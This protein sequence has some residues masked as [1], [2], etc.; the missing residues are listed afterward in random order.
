QLVRTPGPAAARNR[1]LA[2]RAV[3]IGELL[4]RGD[5]ARRATPDGPPVN[6]EP[7]VRPARV[8]DEPRDVAVDVGVTAP[9]PVDPEHPDAAVGQVAFLARRA[10]RVRDELA[11][12]I[13]D[14]AVFAD[15]FRGEHPVAVDLRTPAHDRRQPSWCWHARVRIPHGPAP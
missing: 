11:G 14:A 5:P 10:H 3:V 9:P 4:A 12:I 6:L 2:D 8:I 1:P 13:D 7:A 15:R